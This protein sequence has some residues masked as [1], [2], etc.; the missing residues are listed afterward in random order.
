MTFDITSLHTYALESG[1]TLK[2]SLR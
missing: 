1:S 2:L